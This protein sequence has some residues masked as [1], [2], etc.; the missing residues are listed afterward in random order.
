MPVK[1]VRIPQ[2]KITNVPKINTKGVTRRLRKPK[3]PFRSDFNF[4][5]L[6]E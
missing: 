6:D 1:I 2:G 3:R 5:I 4:S